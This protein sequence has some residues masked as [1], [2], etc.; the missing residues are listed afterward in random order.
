[1][2]TEDRGDTLHTELNTL[3]SVWAYA[4]DGSAP[5]RRFVA[6]GR[7]S[8]SIAK[9]EDNEPTGLHVS[10]GGTSLSDL[11]GT[12]NDLE[13]ARGFLTRQHG[14]NVLWEIRKL[15]PTTH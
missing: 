9:G 2:A 5:A 7:D 13:N 11:P 1:M 10:S 3:D 4:T 14:E 8:V 6:L 12:L 15:T